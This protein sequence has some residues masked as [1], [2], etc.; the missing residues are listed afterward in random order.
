MS[1]WVDDDRGLQAL[2]AAGRH[3]ALVAVDTEFMRG[4]N[5]YPQPCLLQIG[6]D[7]RGW[8]VDLLAGLEIAALEPLFSDPGT[9]QVYHACGEDLEIL[10]L[11]GLPLPP[12]LFDTQVAASLTGI[13]FNLSLQALVLIVLGRDLPK[14]ATRTDWARRPLQPEQLAYAA[15]DVEWLPAVHHHLQTRLEELGRTAW[16]GEEMQALRNRVSSAGSEEGDLLGYLK[17]RAGWTLA[18]RQQFMLRNLVDLRESWARRLNVPRRWLCPD[19]GLVNLARRAPATLAQLQKDGDVAGR[20]LE[21]FGREV[22]EGLKRWSGEPTPE[23][24]P[25]IPGPL[26]KQMKPLVEA[27]RGV[28]GAVARETGLPE[29]LLANRAAVE[30]TV[31]WLNDQEQ[32]LPA[33][34]TGWRGTLL[35]ERILQLRPLGGSQESET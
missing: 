1:T 33:M 10:R 25:C 2:L 15:A 8:L 32:S 34:L 11:L 16:F 7:G 35:H 20:W 23:G 9:I 4:A 14:D 12:R 26:P 17:L 19:D 5:Y 29:G 18:P 3:A 6:I 13:G 21:P 27:V 22:L 28:V 24:F 31:L 30:A